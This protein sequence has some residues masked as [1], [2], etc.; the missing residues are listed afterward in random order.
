MTTK[1]AKM[2]K[3]YARKIIWNTC[4]AKKTVYIFEYHEEKSFVR[5]SMESLLFPLYVVRA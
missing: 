5:F 3:N 2:K 4:L 1:P